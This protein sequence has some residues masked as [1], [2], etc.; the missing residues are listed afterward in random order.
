MALRGGSRRYV[1]RLRPSGAGAVAGLVRLREDATY[2]ITGGF[3]GMGL[4]VAEWMVGRGARNLVLA[5]RSGIA[6]EEARAC[7]RRLETA[8]AQVAAVRADVG[9]EED[10]AGL[11]EEF[12]RA[13]PP[14]R[15]VVH[16]A[17]VFDDRVLM[18]HDRERFARVLAPKVKGAWNLHR[19]TREMPLDFFVLFSSAAPYLGLVGLGNYTAANAFLDALAHYRRGRGLPALSVAWGGWTR[20]GMAGALGERREEQWMSKGLD[21]LTPDEGLRVLNDLMLR[22]VAQVR[23]AEG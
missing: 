20:V 6:S 12:R 7:L 22:D 14:L 10:V 21:S 5:G 4:R 3:G 8:G 18:R 2:L 1:A 23:G 17:G 11:L 15:G 13:M 19:L 16:A 9:R